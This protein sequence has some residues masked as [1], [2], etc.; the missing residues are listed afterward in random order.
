MVLKD[1]GSITLFSLIILTSELVTRE[2]EALL[3]LPS[4]KALLADPSFAVYVKKY[5]QDEDAFFV[6]YAEAHLKHSEP[7]FFDA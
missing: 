5:E 6:D 3:Q 2:K 7:G 1:H 4:D